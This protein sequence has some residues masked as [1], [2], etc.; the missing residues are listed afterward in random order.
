MDIYVCMCVCACVKENARDIVSERERECVCVCVRE[1]ESERERERKNERERMRW[2]ENKRQR[3]GPPANR[4]KE[5]QVR[6]ET[7]T[8]LNSL[9]ASHD[10][11]PPRPLAPLPPTSR[12]LF[13]IRE[14]PL[15]RFQRV[16]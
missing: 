9:P 14:I 2:R 16:Q 1:R 8:T 7:H 6:L 12:L 10:H 3:E 15:L 11:T 5:Q 4:P 13:A